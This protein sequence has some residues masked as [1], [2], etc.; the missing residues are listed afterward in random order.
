MLRTTTMIRFAPVNC[1]RLLVTR[2]LSTPRE[3]VRYNLLK[4]LGHSAWVQRRTMASTVTK[5]SQGPTAIVMMNMG[6]PGSLDEVEPFLT[7]LFTDGDIIPLGPF[8]QKLGR[9]IA[10]RRTPKVRKNYEMIGGRSPILPW[11]EIQG[12]EM[13]KILDTLSPQTAPHLPFPMFRYANP[14]TEDVLDRMKASGVRRAVAFTQYPQYSCTTTGSSLNEL[15]VQLTKKNMTNDFTWSIIDRW[16]TQ[17]GLIKGFAES[18]QA[19]L[20][21]YPK[22]EQDDTIIVFS[23]HSLPMT[24][25]NKGD[26]YIN[27]V[28]ATSYAV[29]QQLGFRNKYINAWQSQVGPTRWMAPQTMDVLTW[30][31]KKGH[32]NAI[33][34]PIAFTSDHIETL[35]E[36][37]EYIAEAKALGMTGVRRM[38]GLNDNASFIKGMADLVAGHLQKNERFSTQFLMCCPGCNKESCKLRKEFYN[39]LVKQRTCEPLISETQ[40]AS[41]ICV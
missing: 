9:F 12:K 20:D 7:R 10:R 24:Q 31:A 16:P 39:K 40:N 28:A 11:T 38:P 27:E 35:H 21:T 26:S 5:N 22:N 36:L 30:L 37:E 1:G 41:G 32:K 13:C 19:I 23:A 34:V 18:I 33:L 29:M 4:K 3:I 14:L 6:G 8:Q 17:P 15:R 25:I 2:F